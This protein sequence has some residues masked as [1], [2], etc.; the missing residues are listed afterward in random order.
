MYVFFP[1]T[2]FLPSSLAVVPAGWMLPGDQR[3]WRCATREL[4]RF[5]VA[6]RCRLCRVCEFFFCVSVF[7]LC[8]VLAGDLANHCVRKAWAWPSVHQAD[9]RV[10][11]LAVRLAGDRQAIWWSGCQ[12]GHQIGRQATLRSGCRAGTPPSVR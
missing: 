10:C 1:I 2:P 12:S 5:G 9:G 6:L 3:R 4:L 8:G 7:F 11:H